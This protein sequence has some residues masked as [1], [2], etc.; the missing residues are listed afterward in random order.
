MF[1][2][3]PFF[4]SRPEINFAQG[5]LYETALD[6]GR[7]RSRLRSGF[8]QFEPADREGCGVVAIEKNPLCAGGCACDR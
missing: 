4:L 2:T 3:K 5:R 8:V 1:L 6:P 7:R